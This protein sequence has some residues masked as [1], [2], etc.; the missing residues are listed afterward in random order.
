MPEVSTIITENKKNIIIRTKK[1]NIWMF[2]SNNEMEIEKSIFV[3]N[4]ITIETTQIVISGI[5]SKL[6][7]KVEWS[8]EKI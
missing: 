6:N 5:T 1:N 8:L 2:K 3:R 7:T 4:D